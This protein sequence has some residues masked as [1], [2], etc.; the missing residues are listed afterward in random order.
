MNKRRA[1]P[2]HILQRISRYLI[3]LVIPLIRALMDAQDDVYGWLSGSWFDLLVVAAI[4]GFGLYNW[5]VFTFM[6]DD[7]SFKIDQGI[8]LK[9]ERWIPF[10]KVTAISL[11]KPWYFR[12]I[13]AVRLKVDTDGGGAKHPDFSITLKSDVADEITRQYKQSLPLSNDQDRAFTPGNLY[14]IIFSILSSSSLTGIIYLYAAFRQAGDILGK[15][16][17]NRLVNRFADL[18]NLVSFG[19]PP[20]FAFVAAVIL[21]CWAIS[22]TLNLLKHLR[23]TVARIQSQL[24]ITFGLFS[25]RKFSIMVKRINF[26]YLRQSLMLSML[27]VT[28]VFI[29]C[30]GY[31]KQ[32][33]EL[34]VLMP[35]GR[36]KLLHKKLK[37]L[38]PEFL[39]LPR[40]LKPRRA[41]MMRFIMIPVLVVV[42]IMACG[43]IALLNIQGFD[44]M[45]WFLMIV[46]GI[47]AIWWLVVKG[48][49]YRFTGIGLDS[50]TITLYYTHGFKV[51]TSAIP[52]RKVSM[53]ELSQS[54]F[55]KS[56][57][58]CDVLIFTNAENKQKQTV[59]NLNQSEVQERLLPMLLPRLTLEQVE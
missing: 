29:H 30:T 15:D 28:S 16:L 24:D 45:I 26:L 20:L 14:I 48:Y 51:I 38:L 46:L 52:V 44:S 17:S 39:F 42:A 5:F 43:M 41:D 3:L 54:M 55:Q 19:L 6:V 47:P 12:P 25:I 23:F 1:H 10:A 36:K 37:L 21:L 57:N 8:F 35:S 9:S 18:A 59:V 33:T 58:A 50:T 11:E 40:V 22:F 13:G 2:I 32:K 27:G 53:I 49:A 7:R 56:T 31:G 34:S 4:L